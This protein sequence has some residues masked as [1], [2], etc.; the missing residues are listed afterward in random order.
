MNTR[1][2][3][4]LRARGENRKARKCR[5]DVIWRKAAERT[6][7]RMS[8]APGLVSRRAKALFPFTTLAKAER[9]ESM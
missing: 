2:R 7:A 8:C 6:I 3:M 4:W 1:P 5:G 9:Y